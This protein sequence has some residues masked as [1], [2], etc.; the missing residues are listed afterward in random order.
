[1]RGRLGMRTGF[2]MRGVWSEARVEIGKVIAAWGRLVSSLSLTSCYQGK[3][4]T[5]A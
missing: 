1:M 5:K 4:R 3:A 2:G